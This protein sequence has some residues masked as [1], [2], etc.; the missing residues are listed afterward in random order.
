M[1]SDFQVCINE[2]QGESIP[3]IRFID[4]KLTQL[5]IT[6]V[7]VSTDE[8]KAEN[9]LELDSHKNEHQGENKISK[10]KYSEKKEDLK[11]EVEIP[12]KKMKKD[13]HLNT[14]HMKLNSASKSNNE[15]KIKISLCD[16]RGYPISSN[17]TDAHKV[18][19]EELGAD[20]NTLK[21]KK[22]AAVSSSGKKLKNNL[23]GKGF[24]G[25]VKEN[26][27]KSET[28]EEPIFLSRT[29][30]VFKIA[31]VDN[32]ENH[33]TQKIEKQAKHTKR[34]KKSKFRAV[35][36]PTSSHGDDQPIGLATSNDNVIDRKERSFNPAVRIL[37]LVC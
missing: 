4:E 20:R 33:E 12:M 31:S 16:D 36:F 7:E 15:S 13:T 14:K 21:K 24:T 27:I 28:K 2:S 29:V 32:G 37:D 18:F 8:V 23:D 9:V 35:K 11:E 5:N 26:K 34:S 6:L 3:E 25:K 22:V 30:K 17:K 10:E 19:N 1:V